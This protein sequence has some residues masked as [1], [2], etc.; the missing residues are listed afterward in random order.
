MVPQP[1]YI[2]GGSVRER[3]SVSRLDPGLGATIR[4]LTNN[5]NTLSSVTTESDLHAGSSGV[6]LWDRLICGSIDRVPVCQSGPDF[7]RCSQLL[8]RC[9]PFC[10]VGTELRLSRCSKLL[11]IES[12]RQKLGRAQR[13]AKPACINCKDRWSAPQVARA[14]RARSA[15]EA[16]SRPRDRNPKG[17]DADVA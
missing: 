13:N 11:G 3:R 9:G 7:M 6:H 14:T 16:L 2:S 1:Q 17:A 15:K 12:A 5:G 4:K 10:Q 8:N